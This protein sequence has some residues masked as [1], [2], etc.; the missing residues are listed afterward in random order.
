MRKNLAVAGTLLLAIGTG[1]ALAADLPSEKGPPAFAP[2]PPPPVFSWTGVY[3]GANAGYTWA[4][5]HTSSVGTDPTSDSQ[6]TTGTVPASFSSTKGGVAAG[7]QIG[8]NYEFPMSGN[9][10]I[11][12]GL[13]ADFDYMG[14]RGS[15]L[16]VDGATGTTNTYRQV[17]DDLGTVRGRLGLAF[18][19]VLV[20]ATG[21]FA[22]GQA[23]YNH[24][25]NDQAGAPIWAGSS[26]GGRTG[27]AVG[28]GVEYALAVPGF[29]PGAVTLRAEFLHY[30]LGHGNADIPFVI[31][32]GAGIGPFHDSYHVEGNVAR[33][34]INYL[35]DF[36][37]PPTPIVAKY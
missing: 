4:N 28:G 6:I 27:Y 15:S 37:A 1:S 12:T 22:Y 7:G 36:G 34:G 16:V 33:V 20:Y 3:V 19:R 2:P 31:A 13:E 24:S 9:V 5:N 8:F 11:V 29:A 14:A 26:S 23:S 17:L 18:D 10:G 32:P 25:F 30:D 35:F 21:G